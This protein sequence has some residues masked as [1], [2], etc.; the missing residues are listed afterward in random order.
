MRKKWN[1]EKEV[2]DNC[3]EHQKHLN[4]CYKNYKNMQSA[5]IIECFL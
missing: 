4:T 3:L 5:E 1:V 2:K